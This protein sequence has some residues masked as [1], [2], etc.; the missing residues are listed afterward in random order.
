VVTSAVGRRSKHMDHNLEVA[1]QYRD[2]DSEWLTDDNVRDGDVIIVSGRMGDHGIAILSFREGYG[3]E[4]EVQSDVA[5]LNHLISSVLEVGGAVSMKDPTR[6]GLANMLN[7]WTSKSGVGIELDEA[8]IPLSEPTINACELLGL[9]PLSIGNEGK[10]VIACV[11]E[12]AEEILEVLKKD[13]L[14][15]YA[16]IIGQATS[17]HDRVVLRT[18]IGGKRILEP[19]IG[20]PV[21]RI[22]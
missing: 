3:F 14:G 2:V 13:P 15:K 17:A 5:P 11:P 21:P 20:D 4:S 9:D 18:E 1:R 7:E 16:A 12:K 19:P 10:V 22:C 8:S 6:G